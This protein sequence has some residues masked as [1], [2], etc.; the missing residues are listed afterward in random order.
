METTREFEREMRVATIC[1]MIASGTILPRGQLAKFLAESGVILL[2]CASILA[3]SLSLNPTWP[4]IRT[5][6]VMLVGYLAVYAWLLL[7]GLAKPFRL[8]AF[9]GVGLLFS[10]S[11]SISL[12]FGGA[13][14]N[15]VLLFRDFYEIPKCWIPV[16]FFGFAYEAELS[17]RG[18]T[19]L[20]DYFGGAIVLVCLYG[21]AQFLRLGIADWL[22]RYYTDYGHNYQALIKYNRILATMANPNALGQLMSWALCIYVLAFLFDVGGRMRNLGIALMCAITVALTGSRYGL[23]ASALGLLIIAWFSVAAKRRGGKLIALL[24]VIALG[25]PLFLNAANTSYF[26]ARRFEELRNPLR[27]DSLRERLDVLWL[28]AG[29]YISSS[30]WVGH[31]PAKKIFS[32]VFTDSEYLDMLKF[33]GVVGFLVYLGYYLWPLLQMGAALR[34]VPQLGLELEERLR[35]NLLVLRA[36]FVLFC[37]ALFMNIGEFTFYNAFLVAFFWIWGGLAVRAG[38]FITEVA[39][40]QQ[41]E[42]AQLASGFEV[43]P[44]LGTGGM[45]L[46]TGNG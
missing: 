15:H 7:A 1:E 4:Y 45:P 20:L 11:V 36:G 18:L 10:V 2:L 28:D 23:L 38:H 40:Q 39:A 41:V 37:L 14:L 30:P 46:V 16:L 8:N 33:Y 3:P 22:N 31:G 9:Y 12:V 35:A 34:K 24:L 13:I 26:A 6:T 5:E 44:A 32:D 42:E 27:V 25:A 43:V 29:E 19:K 17:E 21:W